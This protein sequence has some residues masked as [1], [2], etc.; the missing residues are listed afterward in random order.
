MA[1]GTGAMFRARTELDAQL[2]LQELAARRGDPRPHVRHGLRRLA[3]FAGLVL[4]TWGV[5]S[6]LD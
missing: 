4:A 3:P 1:A 6:L 2:L 5:T